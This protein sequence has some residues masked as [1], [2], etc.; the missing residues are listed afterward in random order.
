MEGIFNFQYQ[1]GP[2]TKRSESSPSLPPEPQTPP[3]VFTRQS[4]QSL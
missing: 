4:F 2:H 1:T 3:R